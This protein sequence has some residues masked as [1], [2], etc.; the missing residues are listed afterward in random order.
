MMLC[1]ME[2]ENAWVHETNRSWS[3]RLT[4]VVILVCYCQCH[5]TF[6]PYPIPFPPRNCRGCNYKYSSSIW[7]IA[8]A[9]VV[10]I[11]IKRSLKFRAMWCEMCIIS[12]LFL[13]EN[14]IYELTILNISIWILHFQNLC[15][16]ISTWYLPL[17]KYLE[18]FFNKS[19]IERIS[20]CCA[21][22]SNHL[23]CIEALQRPAV[24]YLVSHYMPFSLV[25]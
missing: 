2:V 19:F 7:M 13:P 4:A 17:S 22:L 23:Y 9:K 11:L 1:I 14:M 16:I 18:C 21:Y 6:L 25:S 10:I 3:S 8:M 20:V 5:A 15:T 24:Q 12:V